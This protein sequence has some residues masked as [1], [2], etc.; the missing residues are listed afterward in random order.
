MSTVNAARTSVGGRGT[1]RTTGLLGMLYPVAVT[2]AG[3]PGAR[4]AARLAV[5]VSRMTLL[6]LVRALPEQPVSNP[7]V[8]GVD[9]F[10]LLRGQVYASVL[11]DM[12]THRTIDVLTERCKVVDHCAESGLVALLADRP[13]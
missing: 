5:A 8:L 9:D 13:E 11:L 10:A 6:W 7:R 1:H 12:S 4:L 2:L 3:R